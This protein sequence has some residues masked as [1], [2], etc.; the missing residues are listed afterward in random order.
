MKRTFFALVSALLLASGVASASTSIA[1]PLVASAPSLDPHA[2]SFGGATLTLGWDATNSAD[3]SE[4]ATV[5]LVSDSKYLYVRYDV[6]QSEPLIGADGG[7]NVAIDLWP[8][9]MSGDY[10]HFGVQLNGMH[11]P[12]STKNTATWEGSATS[13]AGSYTVTM[14]IPT[15]ALEGS[16]SQVQFSRWIT[17]T[18]TQQVWSHQSGQAAD[19]VA[20]AGTITLASSVGKN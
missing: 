11:S 6:P 19:A 13:R 14:K 1:V 2:A 16:S 8:N 12:D 4:A 20:Q 5:H 18:A 10:Y 3:A 17:T 9:G 7:D 15:S